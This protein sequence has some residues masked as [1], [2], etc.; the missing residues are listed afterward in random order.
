MHGNTMGM[1]GQDWD[2]N[3]HP[4]FVAV[5]GALGVT[6]EELQTA[7]AEGKTVAVIAEE[8]GVELQAV[9]DVALATATQHIASHVEEGVLT[10]EQADA[11]LAW[12]Q[13]NIASMP[14]FGEHSGGMH[15]AGGMMGGMHGAGGMMGGMHSNCPMGS[16]MQ[17]GSNGMRGMMGRWNRSGS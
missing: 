10:Q 9:Y 7:F 5:A 12:M 1:M 3:E 13:E 15:G 6:P 11:R 14:I 4:M 17:S 16:D 8:N 2:L